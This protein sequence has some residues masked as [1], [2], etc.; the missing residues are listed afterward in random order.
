MK[1]YTLYLIIYVFLQQSVMVLNLKEKKTLLNPSV[2]PN[3]VP[4]SISYL[5]K[6]KH[7]KLSKVYKLLS[8]KLCFIKHFVIQ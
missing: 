3:D 1:K 6:L 5:I 7:S 8:D 4:V 2:L